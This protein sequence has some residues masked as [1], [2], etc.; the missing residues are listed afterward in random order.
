MT[1]SDLIVLRHEIDIAAPACAVYDHV[2]EARRWPYLLTPTIH[3]EQ[4]QLTPGQEHL[5]LWAFAKDE[6]RSWTSLRTLDSALL[7]IGFRQEVPA[8]PL[9]EMS[10][11]WR[12]S[13]LPG[14]RAHVELLHSFRVAGGADTVA[15]ARQ[16]TDRNSVAELAKLRDAL[17]QGPDFAQTVVT[18]TDAL[19]IDADPERVYD[20]LYRADLWPERI[21]HVAR[22][23]LTGT[24]PSTQ[25]ME[26]DTRAADGSAH[27]THSV[28]ICFPQT[29]TIV[30]KQT[31]PPEL[32]SAHVG[33]WTVRVTDTGVEAASQHTAVIRPEKVAAV[34]G[35]D[36]TLEQAC[37]TVRKMLGANS[38]I[39]LE[40]AALNS[41]ARTA[42]E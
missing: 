20:F 14:G 30:Y 40:H 34:L 7:R 31:A 37:R 17:E 39:T 38:M 32:L 26:M 6:V 15:W 23:E 22:L 9:R 5:K 11:E 28:R 8:A 16:A 10:G 3:V 42:V 35:P 12:I 19:R 1:Q 36:A 25:V 13:E 18:F 21:P 29:R 4:E 33:R 41:E 24:D 27:T 2:A